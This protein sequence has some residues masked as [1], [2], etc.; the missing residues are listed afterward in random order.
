VGDIDSATHGIYAG[1]GSVV[2]SGKVESIAGGTRAVYGATFYAVLDYNGLDL[3]DSFPAITVNFNYNGLTPGGET[4]KKAYL[5][6]TGLIP[7]PTATGY[8]V[9]D[10][11]E[12]AAY[13]GIPWKFAT[14][15]APNTASNGMVLFARL[16]TLLDLSDPPNGGIT[17]TEG[18]FTVTATATAHV[19]EVSGTDPLVIMGDGTN[20]GDGWSVN[21]WSATDIT[22][23]AGTK[24]VGSGPSDTRALWLRS[25][26]SVTING[27]GAP[28]VS[29]IYGRAIDADGSITI[30]GTLGDITSGAGQ[31]AVRAAGTNLTISGTIG[32]INTGASGI[33][34]VSTAGN[35]TISGSVGSITAN[36][37]TARGISAGNSVT[38]SGSVG[39]ISTGPTGQE[40]INAI[41]GS[42]TIEAAGSVGNISSGTYGIRAATSVTISGTVGNIDSGQR[43]ISANNDISISGDLGYIDSGTDG[44]ATE[45]GNITVSGSIGNIDSYNNGIKGYR[46]VTISGDVGNINAGIGYG[47]GAMISS[48]EISGSV[49]DIYSGRSAAIY[50]Y[51]YILIT[52]KVGNITAGI[53]MLVSN[54]S[55]VVSGKVQS[56]SASTLIHAVSYAILD[57]TAL[58]LTV[59]S[60]T[61]P[62]LDITV[63]FDYGTWSPGGDELKKAYFAG[64]NKIPKP[65]APDYVWA[66]WYEDPEFYGTIWDYPIDIATNGLTL[67]ALDPNILH[68]TYPPNDGLTGTEGRFTVDATTHVITVAGTDPL[69]IMGDGTNG[70]AGWS[71][72][73]SQA[74]NITLK[75]GT[76]MVGS[77]GGTALKINSAGMVTID[78]LGTSPTDAPTISSGYLRAIEVTAGSLTITGR[79]GNIASGAVSNCIEA[80]SGSITI[81]GELGDI[82]AGDNGIL[83]SAV[84]LISGSVGDINTGGHGI[85]SNLGIM[86]S[87]SVGDIYSGNVGILAYTWSVGDITISGSVGNIHGGLGIAAFKDV[88]ITGTV[89]NVVAWNTGI[90]AYENITVTGTV[91]EVSARDLWGFHAEMGGLLISGKVEKI[92]APAPVIGWPTAVLDYTGLDLSGSWPPYITVTFDYGTTVPAGDLLQ[93]AYLSGTDRIPEPTAPGYDPQDWYDITAGR[94]LWDLVNDPAW[95]GLTLFTI[96]EVTYT[97]V[98]TGGASRTADSTG[99]RVTFSDD[100]FGLT[101]ADITVTDGTGK[102]VVGGLTESTGTGNGSIWVIGLSSVLTEGDVTVEIINFGRF[103]VLTATQTV[104]V[105]KNTAPNTYT[106]TSSSDANS[107]VSPTGT[108]TVSKGASITF[109]FTAKNGYHVSAVTIDEGVRLDMAQIKMGSYTFS[110]VKANHTIKVAAAAGPG[111][112]GDDRDGDDTD[113]TDDSEA[114][115]DNNIMLWVA[116][117][118]VIIIIGVVAL[119]VIMRRKST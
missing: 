42:I 85:Y 105:F 74:T 23:R 46:R 66:K 83:A 16:Q 8:V 1:S 12:D 117:I 81:S 57:Y 33:I 94:A 75:K 100:V 25:T 47:I 64:A 98:Q 106:I 118:G 87:G 38:I 2:V 102:V 56:I 89:G 4:I 119:F 30:T 114:G 70:G 88:L 96:N 13:S 110:D 45:N 93:K 116:V 35:I 9:M 27:E 115:S 54:G 90:H 6:G 77:S 104:D 37:G 111:P 67:Y 18:R 112:G 62:Y 72:T 58:D 109:T 17:G 39:N 68:L 11:Y 34:A 44:I 51:A 82:N 40:G 10:W 14:S 91:G 48:L 29:T 63:N 5:A 20:G 43:G 31:N 99:I 26:G 69:I 49:G 79:L 92:T 36:G 22:L 55:V 53:G 71:V 103:D 97:A 41:S 52:G 84:V 113:D 95:D 80:T 24:I 32:N 7:K 65:T 19:I 61:F 28:T 76:K 78:G 107:D 3:S 101:L 108:I 60:Y 59:A 50:G 86:I 73:V 21:V 15:N